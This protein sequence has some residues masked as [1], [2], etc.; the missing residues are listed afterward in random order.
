MKLRRPIFSVT[1]L[2]AALA[3]CVNEGELVVAQG[4]GVTTVRTACPAGYAFEIA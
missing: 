1:V 4:V 2:A 3:G